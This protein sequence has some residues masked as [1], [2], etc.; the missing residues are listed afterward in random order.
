MPGTK[1]GQEEDEAIAAL[2]T[3]ARTAANYLRQCGNTVVMP[4]EQD[5]AAAEILYHILCRRESNEHP[6][7]DAADGP[8]QVVEVGVGVA[9]LPDFAPVN[10]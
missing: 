2:Q 5:E 7:A 9:G 8:V 4:E 3:A 10:A 1:R 6:F